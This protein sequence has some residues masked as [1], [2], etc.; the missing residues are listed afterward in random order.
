MK[1]G[2]SNLRDKYSTL[3]RLKYALLLDEDYTYLFSFNDPGLG[4]CD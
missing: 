1:W 3:A 4:I 2:N